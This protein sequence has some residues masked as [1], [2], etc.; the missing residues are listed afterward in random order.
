MA[1]CSATEEIMYEPLDFPLPISS[2]YS[3]VQRSAR[4]ALDDAAG[5]RY[6]QGKIQRLVHDLFGGRAVCHPPADLA[7]LRKRR[8]AEALPQR[9]QHALIHGWRSGTLGSDSAPHPRTG[10]QPGRRGDYPEYAGEDG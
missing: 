5:G 10:R 8:A 7:A 9:W 4:G 2:P 6:G 1:Y 3:V